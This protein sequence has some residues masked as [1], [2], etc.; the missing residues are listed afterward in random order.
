MVGDQGFEHVEEL[1]L[2]ALLLRQELDVVDQQQVQRLVVALEGIDR[3]AP[4]RRH[5]VLEELV[6][7]HVADGGC[8]LAIEDGVADRMHQ[9]G[10]AEADTAVDEE[11]VVG[12]AGTIRHLQCR[13]PGE[14]VGLA[15]HETGEG[16]VRIE[17]GALVRRP[18][19]ERR[20]YRP[21]VAAVA[22][23]DT[24]RRSRGRIARQDVSRPGIRVVRRGRSGG[25]LTIRRRFR[26]G[27]TVQDLELHRNIRVELL[28]EAGADEPQILLAHDVHFDLRRRTQAHDSVGRVE[29]E[30]DQRFDPGAECLL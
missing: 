5:H 8:R 7:G 26:P 25:E 30:E 24:A 4:Y 1:F 10:L 6:G 20:E 27:G 29:A 12:A 9:V 22:G 2:R 14:V 21:G 15:G 19:S 18:R 3:L 16:Q 11:R 17:L 28:L 13:R 23:V